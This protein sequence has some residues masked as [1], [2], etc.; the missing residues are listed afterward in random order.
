MINVMKL[1]GTVRLLSVP[2][3]ESLTVEPKLEQNIQSPGNC[4]GQETPDFTSGVWW[5]QPRSG[6]AWPWCVTSASHEVRGRRG[7]FPASEYSLTCGELSAELGLCNISHCTASGFAFPESRWH[8]DRSSRPRLR[9]GWEIKNLSSV[10]GNE[11]ITQTL[12]V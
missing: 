10:E 5:R 1:W 2:K 8:L 3:V 7:N 6:I 12:N 9:R 11:F 4:W